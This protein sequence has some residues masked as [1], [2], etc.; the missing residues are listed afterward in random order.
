MKK[1]IVVLTGAGI[2]AESGIKTF[3]DADGLWEGYD[4]TEVASPEGF[5]RNPALVLDFYNQRRRQLLAVKPNK[6]H[7][8]LVTLQD[9][10]E[11]QIITQNIDDLHERAG[12]KKIIHLHGELLKV[13]STLD[14]NDILEWKKDLLLGDLCKKKS[15]LRPHIVW[16]GEEVTMMDSAIEITKKADILIIIGTS[17]AVYPAAGL[18]HYS[19]PN[20]PI[21][22][23]DPKPQINKNQFQNLTIINEVATIGTEKLIKILID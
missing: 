4:V 20:I 13:R 11:V 23:I 8:N 1:K 15:Q 16:F 3:R 2:S 22:F 6:A 10:Y 18:V 19:Q 17:M 7:A 9:F 14:K 21:Y 12:N 5:V